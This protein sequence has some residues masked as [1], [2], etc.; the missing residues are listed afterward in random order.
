MSYRSPCT[1]SDFFLWKM[2]VDDDEKAFEKL[3]EL[4]YPALSV[5]AKKYV[6]EQTIR[7]DIVQDVFV[8][9]WE[10]RKKLTI[11]TSVRNYLIIS[12]RNRC[13][14][15]LHKEGLSR[16]YQEAISAKH[17]DK[18]E[19]E[20]IYLLTELYELLDKTLAKLPETY[21]LVFEMHSMQGKDYNEIAEA[22]NISVRTAKRYKSQVIDVLQKELKDYLPLIVLIYPGIFN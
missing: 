17:A 5:Y 14:N 18:T 9:L 1:E 12:V 7:E 3:F 10:D 8:T 21:R 20:E 16:Q 6:E 2:T 13:F 19:N 22:L 4:F 15:H 11:T